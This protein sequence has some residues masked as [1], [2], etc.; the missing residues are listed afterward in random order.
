MPSLLAGQG[1][2]TFNQPLSFNTASVTTMAGMFRVCSARAP[3]PLVTLWTLACTLLTRQ[4]A[5]TLG[6]PSTHAANLECPPFGWA[7]RGRVQPAA[8]LQ[9]GQRHHHGVHVLCPLHPLPPPAPLPS[10][11]APASSSPEPTRA[12]NAVLLTWQW[13]RAFNQTLNFDTSGVTTMARM[14]AVRRSARA[15]QLMIALQTLTGPL[16]APPP[17]HTLA[18]PSPHAADL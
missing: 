14:F 6:P 7:E 18:P 12:L 13:A 16:L 10:A 15:P 11:P 4:P 3:H 17:A 1:A 8:E 5:H 2:S 9:R